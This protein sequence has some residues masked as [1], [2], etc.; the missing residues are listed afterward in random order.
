MSMVVVYLIQ[1]HCSQRMVRARGGES[2]KVCS[3]FMMNHVIRRLHLCSWGHT[4]CDWEG[5]SSPLK[6][7]RT[8]F[9]INPKQ[10]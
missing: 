2:N 3:E 1:N 6:V 5:R 7:T 10:C 8:R 4:N 9:E